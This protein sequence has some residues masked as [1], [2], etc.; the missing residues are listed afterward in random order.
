MSTLIP[1]ISDDTRSIDTKAQAAVDDAAT[2]EALNPQLIADLQAG[3][4]SLAETLEIALKSLTANKLRTLLTALG[5]IIGVGAVVA[6]L[7]IGR[8]SQEA[9]TSAITANGSNLLTVRSG[10]TNAGGVGGQVGSGQTLTTEDAKALADPQN[11]PD[12][13]LVSPE[14]QGNGQLVAGSQNTNAR[15][16]GAMPAYLP[17]HNLTL[18]EGDFISDDQVSSIANVVVLGA[19]I[20]TELFPD[21]DALGQSLRVNRQSFKVIGVLAAQGGGGFGSMDDGVIVPLSTAQRKLFGGRAIQG[22]AALVSTIVVQARDQNSVTSALDQISQTLR[23]R[24]NLPSN[25]S[26]DDFS[27]INQQDILN[28]VIQT[29]QTL[30][31]FLGAIAAISLVVGGIGIMNIMLVSV[32][33][34]TREIGLRKALGAREGDILTQFL[35]EALIISLLGGLIGLALGML[36]AMAV[37]LSGLIR[38]QPSLG[39]AAMAVG[40]AM[41]VGLFFGIAPARSAARLDPIDALRYE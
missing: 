25:G 22:G 9:I 1:T 27:V 31:L 32:R 4:I 10:A 19:N 33:E 21:G 8:G 23:D 18:A 20:A 24:H 36:I 26:A 28:S 17:I 13:A 30:T 3:G 40:F 14:Y 35:I 37:N 41:A 29:T 5:V 12:A 6:L 15:I 2:V 39:A 11:V 38:A 7:A 16:A 34:R